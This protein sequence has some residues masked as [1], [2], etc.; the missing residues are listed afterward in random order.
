M[1]TKA[2]SFILPFLLTLGAWLPACASIPPDTD[3]EVTTALLTARLRVGQSSHLTI[4]TTQLD[5]WKV[6]LSNAQ[7]E[8]QVI[9]GNGPT[10]L[11]VPSGM[12]RT[13]V[14]Q[15][16]CPAPAP[17]SQLL[18]DGGATAREFDLKYSLTGIPTIPPIGEATVFYWMTSS[19]D[20]LAGATSS[21]QAAAAAGPGALVPE[22]VTVHAYLETELTTDGLLITSFL[23]E[24]FRQFTVLVDGVTAADIDDGENVLTSAAGQGWIA[25]TSLLPVD[26]LTEATSISV[27][28]Q[29]EGNSLPYETTLNL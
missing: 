24:R 22:T 18:T 4:G 12:V 19:G 1:T 3:I 16:P 28:Q 8:T 5:C 21:M 15:Y 27:V 11:Q 29:G 25:H 14:F 20:T 13:S 23:P 10:T 9:E 17:P 6:L 7:G 26:I 2:R